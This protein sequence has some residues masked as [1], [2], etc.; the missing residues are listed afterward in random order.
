MVAK[1]AGRAGKSESQAAGQGTGRGTSQS[2]QWQLFAPS[3][4]IHPKSGGGEPCAGGKLND[5]CDVYSTTT[6]EGVSFRPIF[7]FQRSK[8]SVVSSTMRY[9]HA[10]LIGSKSKLK[11]WLSFD[12][13]FND[14]TA[15]PQKLS[16]CRIS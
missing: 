2:A 6:N 12:H 4:V 14:I 16:F 5:T 3:A 10:T 13:T 9:A 7:L 1:G 8:C 11:G 15:A